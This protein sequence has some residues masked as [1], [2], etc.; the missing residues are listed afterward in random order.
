MAAGYGIGV[1]RYS[2]TR[3]LPKEELCGLT[4]QLGKAAVSIPSNLTEAKG[5]FTD[6]DRALFFR[7]AR[8]SLL[9][10]ETQI[11]I[12]QRLRYLR[13]EEHTSELQSPCNLVCRLLL[14]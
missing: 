4:A 1:Q 9:E 5:R 7:H 13:S 6:R 8:G 10:L 3:G 14:E 12:S 2:E 11:L